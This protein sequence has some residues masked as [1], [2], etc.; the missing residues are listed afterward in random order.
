[1]IKTLNFLK[2]NKNMTHVE[3]VKH[4]REVH[5]PLVLATWGKANV[6]C[7]R[8]VAYY[9]DEPSNVPYDMVVEQCLEDEDWKKLQELRRS[10]AYEKVRQDYRVMFDGEMGQLVFATFEQNVII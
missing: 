2:R 4:H 9:L 6:T 10:P 7:K 3:C 8:Y 5:A 1:M